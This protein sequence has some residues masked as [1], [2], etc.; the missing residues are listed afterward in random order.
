MTAFKVNLMLVG[1]FVMA[2]VVSLILVLATLAGRTGPTDEYYTEFGNVAGLKYGSQ[3]LFEGYPIGQVESVEPSQNAGKAR[4]RVSV[5][6]TS[7]WQ[8]PEDSIARSVAPGLLAAQTISISAGKSSVMLKPGAMIPSGWSASL[9]DSFSSI[10]GNVDQ[11][12]ER[13]LVPLVDNLN[14]QVTLL[15]EILDKDMHPLVANANRFMKTTADRWPVVMKNVE[16]A[17][18]D[19]TGMSGQMNELLSDERIAALD[20]L[21]TNLDKTAINMQ[22]ATTELEKLTQQ[23]GPDLK[24]ALRDLRFTTEAVSRH[25]ESFSSNLD[26]AALNLQEFSRSIRQNPSLLLRSPD[27]PNDPVP[28]LKRK[29]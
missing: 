8:I 15:G 4:F 10:A 16:T 23:G 24:A 11:L 9:Q 13:S 20:R 19:L 6:I 22:K 26:S 18:N 3:V 14:K 2:A 27:A 1:V 7:G 17:S 25:A 12:T 21:I 5:S 28:P 29:E